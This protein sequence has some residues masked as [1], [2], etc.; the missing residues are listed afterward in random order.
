MKNS[1]L[2][3]LSFTAILLS[4]CADKNK[5]FWD[6]QLNSTLPTLTPQEILPIPEPSKHCK[7]DMESYLLYGLGLNFFNEKKIIDA[8][9]CLIMAAP[10]NNRAFCLL[11]DMV[12]DDDTL[13]KNEKDTIVSNYISYSASNKDWC[14]EYNMYQHHTWGAWGA[15]KDKVLGARWL[16][17]SAL[18]GYPHAQSRLLSHYRSEKD[19]P[20]VYAWSK[21][22]G[23]FETPSLTQELAA[24]TQEQKA[25]GESLY[26][27]LKE[28]VHSKEVLLAEAIE[29]NTASAAAAIQLNYPEVFEGTTPSDRYETTKKAITLTHDKSI[30]LNTFS[31]VFSY[32]AISPHAKKHNL[33]TDILKNEEIIKLLESDE[34]TYPERLDRAK[35]IVN[36]V[37]Q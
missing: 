25:E 30:N 32:V 35:T 14:A 31:K 27:T 33:S 24:I 13:A 5:D 21:I 16:R 10:Q 9:S 3:L 19:L 36:K 29:E 17:R 4:G 23:D 2:Q 11:A 15:P 37:T 22:T 1:T 12:K 6:E 7:P 18:R 34:L 26:L 8:K 20:H 28:N